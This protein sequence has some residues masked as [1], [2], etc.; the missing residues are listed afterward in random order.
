MTFPLPFTDLYKDFQPDQRADT[1]NLPWHS[2][3]IET[4]VSHQIIGNIRKQ[5]AFTDEFEGV[6]KQLKISNYERVFLQ[7]KTGG[8]SDRRNADGRNYDPRNL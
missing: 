3:E 5:T 6:K 1:H 7:R 2:P 8:R 4:Y